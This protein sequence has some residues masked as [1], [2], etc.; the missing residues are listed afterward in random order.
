MR[1]LVLGVVL[2]FTIVGPVRAD[3]GLTDAVA[4]AYFPRTVD[5]GL[6][7]IAH[8]RV[9][10]LSA[11]ACLDH[12]GIRSGTAEVLAWNSGEANPSG[13]AVQQWIKS[14]VHDGILSNSSYGRIGCAELV[15]GAVHWFACVLAAGP[16]PTPSGPS[17][18]LLPNTALPSHGQGVVIGSRVRSWPA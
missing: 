14:P 5:S 1:G 3:G 18:A 6:H 10:Q 13:G 11:C 9:A 12:D 7:S 16:L 17:I 15:S 2:V 4:A 8:E